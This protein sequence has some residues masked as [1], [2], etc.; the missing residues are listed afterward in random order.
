MGL[1]KS[2]DYVNTTT[3]SGYILVSNNGNVLF[4]KLDKLGDTVWTNV[5]AEGLWAREAYSIEQTSDG[6]YIVAGRYQDFSGSGMML[7]KLN[8]SGGKVW[9]KTFSESTSA[10]FCYGRSVHQTSDGGYILAGYTEMDYY[11]TTRHTNFFVVK[12]DSAGNSQWIKHHGGSENEYAFEI[13]PIANGNYIL[14]G[15]QYDSLSNGT[16]MYLLKLNA[17]GDT[18]WT[19]SYGGTF[20]SELNPFGLQPMVLL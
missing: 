1:S 5:Y 6:G 11:D 16:N 14:A 2:A 10:G 12:T 7:L 18:I 4:T 19:H 20:E 15:R 8:S 3:D 17:L 13:H 9:R